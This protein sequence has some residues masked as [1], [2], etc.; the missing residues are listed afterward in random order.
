LREIYNYNIGDKYNYLITT[1]LWEQDPPL[2]YYSK[3]SGEIINKLIYGD[4]IL[5]VINGKLPPTTITQL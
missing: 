4:T 5:Y 1:Y 3:I 2:I